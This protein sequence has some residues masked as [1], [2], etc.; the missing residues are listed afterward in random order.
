MNSINENGELSKEG[1]RRI[2]LPNKRNMPY[3]KKGDLLFNW[4]NGSK[5]LVGKTGYFDWEGEYVFA[6]FLLGIRTRTEILDSKYLWYL[7]NNYRKEGK[8][9][10]FM[11]QSVNGL[12]NREELRLLQIPLPPFEEQKRIVAQVE[13]EQSLVNANKELIAIYN[14]KIK[15]EIN[16]LWEQ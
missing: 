2:K 11:R 4:R 14:Q 5:H 9:F 10:D 6:S 7:L 1:V 13:H 12:F 16:R 3:L 8:Y 15:D